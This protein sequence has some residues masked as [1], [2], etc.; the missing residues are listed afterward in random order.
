MISATVLS[1][2]TIIVSSKLFG[3]SGDA[4]EYQFE[5]LTIA[6]TVLY[7]YYFVSSCKDRTQALLVAESSL[8]TA[9]RLFVLNEVSANIAHEI[10]TPLQAALS[11]S[12]RVRR[13]LEKREGDFSLEIDALNNTKLA[14]GQ[15]VKTLDSVRNLVKTSGSSDE[16]CVIDKALSTTFE[17]INSTTTMHGVRFMVGDVSHLPEVR[18]E[19][20]ELVQILLNLIS[21]SL[22]SLKSKPEKGKEIFVSGDHSGSVVWLE[23][24]DG[25]DGVEVS[26]LN[27]L[28]MAGAS[29][30]VDGLG[31][32]LWVSKSIAERRG[33]TLEYIEKEGGGWC[34]RLSLTCARGDAI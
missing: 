33:G 11:S 23:L 24:F 7:F 19:K 16:S 29:D 8:G 12:Q 26:S 15:A 20:N 6:V 18:I 9:S 28:F 32:G 3:M 25:G 34:F 17:L 5:L 27:K 4:I 31:L 1:S 14:I 30:A 13:R 10:S 21:N 2:I 22:N